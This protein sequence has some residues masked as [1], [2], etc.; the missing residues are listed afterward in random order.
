MENNNRK[1]LS[2]IELINQFFNWLKK[3]TIGLVHFLGK[4]LQVTVKHWWVFLITFLLVMAGAL[5]LSRESAHKYKVGTVLHIAFTDAPFVGDMIDQLANS[6]NHKEELSLAKKLNIPDSVG[7]HIRK[8]K[9]FNVIDFRND[10]IMD[11]VDFKRNHDLS[12]T[13]NVVMDNKLYLQFITK[14]PE[15]LDTVYTAMMRYFN[16]NFY[17]KDEFTS[18]MAHYQRSSDILSK[19]LYRIDSLAES[20]YFSSGENVQLS[21]KETTDARMNRNNLVI[22]ER[23]KPLFNEEL[24]MVLGNLQ[25]ADNIL[26]TNRAPIYTTSGFVV[27]GP[28]NSRIIYGAY[29]AIIGFVL[30]I[31][32]SFLYD[33]RKRI[34]NYLLNK[35]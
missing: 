33:N 35:N 11:V 10:D 17:L 5:Y 24:V 9:H 30:G 4:L 22:G 12:D 15:H 19:E 32:M 27:A 18:K 25:H 16:E 28:I 1:E 29:G 23:K 13:V 21:I 14:K 3:V 20:Y 7:M 2:L 8:M 6:V 26:H 34:S 31:L